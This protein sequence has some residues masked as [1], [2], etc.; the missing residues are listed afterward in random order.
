MSLLGLFSYQLLCVRMNEWVVEFQI[1]GWFDIL[2]YKVLVTFMC[3]SAELTWVSTQGKSL[4]WECKLQNHLKNLGLRLDFDCS[5]FQSK[6]V[7]SQNKKESIQH[8]QKD[9]LIHLAQL[10]QLF[11]DY[12]GLKLTYVHCT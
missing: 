11:R 6:N 2:S 1:L 9:S 10:R 5:Q 3:P 4:F 8:C 7:Q 12:L